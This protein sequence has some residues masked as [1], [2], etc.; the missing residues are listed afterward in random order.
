[1]PIRAP[2]SLSASDTANSERGGRAAAAPQRQKVEEMHDEEVTRVEPLDAGS[3]GQGST[4]EQQTGDTL[5]VE[6]DA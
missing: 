6:N 3:A 2:Q 1:M 4:A 5:A